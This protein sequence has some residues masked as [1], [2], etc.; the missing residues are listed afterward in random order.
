M[1]EWLLLLILVPAVVLPVVLLLG[2]A[3]CGFEAQSSYSPL[4]ITSATATGPYTVKLAWTGGYSAQIEFQRDKKPK[5]GQSAELPHL[6]VVDRLPQNTIDGGPSADSV[7]EY[8]V[9]EIYG[10]GQRGPWSPIVPV[11][12][13]AVVVVA[14]SVTFD[15]VSGGHTD[16]GIGNA[17]TTWSH[18][19]SGNAAAVVV[20]VRWSQTGGIGTPTRTVTY[21]AGA[22]QSLG[23]RGLNDE[24]VNAISG[25]YE[26]F[27]GFRNPPTGA[28]TVSVTVDRTASN[29]SFEA[30]SVSYAQV[31]AFVPAPPVFGTEAGTTMT[32]PVNSAMKEM[33]VQMFATAS[34]PITAYNQTLRFTSTNGMLIG[35][36]PGAAAISFTATRAS[37]VDYAG[38]AV[39][40]TPVT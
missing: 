35:D 6:F 29:L 11:E 17:S 9:R 39:R 4:V 18:T 3:G 16:S 21:G 8:Q 27:F 37:G 30:C 36:A 1:I 23:A 15:T 12:T 38:L 25:V 34:G 14:P 22:M 13:P 2:F 20:G 24:A 40:L 28:Q 33:V 31:S 19:A 26:E 7:Y 5:A 32:Q 10:D